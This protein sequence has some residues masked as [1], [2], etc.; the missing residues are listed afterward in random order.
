MCCIRSYGQGD[1]FKKGGGRGR[2]GVGGVEGVGD[3]ICLGG[4]WEGGDGPG[5][6]VGLDVCGCMYMKDDE[7]MAEVVG[8]CLVCRGDGG[9]SRGFDSVFRTPVVGVEHVKRCDCTKDVFEGFLKK[10]IREYIKKNERSGYEL[11]PEVLPER[12]A[13]IGKYRDIY[14]GTCRDVAEYCVAKK[15]S[16][17]YVREELENTWRLF[18][19]DYDVGKAKVQMI[20][21]SILS[22]QSALIESQEIFGTRGVMEKVMDK[23]GNVR[24]VVSNNE[25]YR[26]KLNEKI[27]ESVK[28]LDQIVEGNKSVSVNI[29]TQSVSLED[30]LDRFRERREEYE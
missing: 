13:L 17:P 24:D 26:I 6:F 30:V 10:R 27:V 1:R 22:F 11:D 8:E 25:Y 14:E 5:W 16:C 21:R 29:N 7:G 2:E 9:V 3:E 4:G 15:I 18:S 28:I 20:V 19:R 12:M 23:V